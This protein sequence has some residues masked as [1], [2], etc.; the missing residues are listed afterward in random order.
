MMRNNGAG[1]QVERVSALEAECLRL[2]AELALERNARHA[3]SESTPGMVALK[4]TRLVYRSVNSAFCRF[5][6]KDEDE[7]IGKTDDELFAKEEADLLRTGDKAVL[8]AL[9]SEIHECTVTCAFGS[10]AL[11]VIKSP[12][13]DDDGRVTGL[14]C[15]MRDIDNGTKD[16]KRMRLKAEA[17]DHIAHGISI[18]ESRTGTILACNRAYAD[19]QGMD[20]GEIE[21]KLILDMYHPDAKERLQQYFSHI[22]TKGDFCYEVELFR[23]NGA[24]LP[25]QLDVVRFH[26]RDDGIQ[27]Q[28]ATLKDISERRT[29]QKALY[30]NERKFRTVVESAPVG[31][32]IQ[33][34]GCYAY[35]NPAALDMYGASDSQE[36]LGH[37]ILERIHPD[38]R[39]QVAERTSILNDLQEAV[40]SMEYVHLR[41]DGTPFD[42]EVMAVPLLYEGQ[43]GAVVFVR[44][45]TERKRI[46][47]ERN[48]LEQ[49]LF[50]TQRLESLGI[51]AA[52]IGHEINNPLNFIRLNCSALKENI[53]DFLTIINEYRRL[54]E[55]AGH[56]VLST[57]DRLAIAEKEKEL[58][59]NTIANEVPQIFADSSRGFDRMSSIISN[60]MRLAYHSTIDQRRLFDVNQEIGEALAIANN[61]YR[62][63]ADVEEKL[64]IVPLVNGNP[65]QIN[66]VL[67]NLIINSTQAIESQK[68][69]SKGKITIHTWHDDDNVYC[70][71][72]DDGPGI[73]VEARSRIFDPFYTT[74]EPGKGTGLGLS[75]SYD[76]IVSKHKGSLS[77]DCPEKGGTIFTMAIPITSE[78]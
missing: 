57:E 26:G 10:E 74:K 55:K 70:S 53:N 27:Y 20:I 61:K 34:G 43:H 51:L 18:A 3:L 59:I 23:K 46:E 44:D 35:L 68:K 66:Q 25:L 5:A 12:L 71:V 8:S 13:F 14:L 78:E 22:A 62:F 29:A 69:S 45:I 52:G 77:Y 32:Y 73:S 49:R 40:D 64:E 75:I 16:E 60:L 33:A 28:V 72:A 63:I 58:A 48:K 54:I 15:R 36:M 76:I 24:L 41:C 31:L 2:K 19:M 30:E 9:N 6:G 7:I 38:F 42:V 21:G 67:L 47:V 1:E 56:S 50:H 11:Q 17:F 4:D 37:P 39:T 65:E